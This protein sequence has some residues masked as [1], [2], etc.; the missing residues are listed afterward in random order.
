MCI[1][2]FLPSAVKQRVRWRPSPDGLLGVDV[3]VEALL[4]LAVPVDAHAAVLADTGLL[5]LQQ[6]ALHLGP[7][8]HVGVLHQLEVVIRAACKSPAYIH[9]LPH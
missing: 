3:E 9:K 1:E 2:N 4:G 8:V 5:A 6:A 7:A